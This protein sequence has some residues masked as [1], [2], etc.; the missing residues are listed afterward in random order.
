V[1]IDQMPSADAIDRFNYIKV[2][3]KSLKIAQDLWLSNKLTPDDRNRL[4]SR[5]KASKITKK[6]DYIIAAERYGGAVGIWMKLRGCSKVRATIDVA[7]TSGLLSELESGWLLREFGELS[8]DPEEVIQQ[9]I[10][11]GNL[12]LRQQPREVY[13]DQAQIHLD[14]DNSNARWRY[15]WK[16][17][18]ASKAG[19][20]LCVTDLGKSGNYL[21]KIKSKLT[22]SD[23]FPPGL[24][25]Q[26]I[27]IEN[28]SQILDLPAEKIRLFEVITKDVIREF[29]A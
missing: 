4:L 29:K 26:I 22:T 9:C 8:D 25:D 10:K 6:Q 28:G 19:G 12:V 13:W 5:C 15:L 2:V 21:T 24:A 17:C 27:D 3:I 11:N 18:R 23:D 14:W 16:L 20:H 1:T 7:H